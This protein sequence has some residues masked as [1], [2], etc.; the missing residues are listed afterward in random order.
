MKRT[1]GNNMEIHFAEFFRRGSEIA[2]RN[3]MEVQLAEFFMK[4]GLNFLNLEVV[5]I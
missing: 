3:N 5:A 2:R 4:K 1:L